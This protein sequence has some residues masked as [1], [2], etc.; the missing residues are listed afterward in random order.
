[1]SGNLRS[2]II[3]L[4]GPPGVGKTTLAFSIAK[5]MK[6]NFVKISVGGITDEAELI[7]HRRTYIGANPGRI[8]SSLKKAKSMNPV[9]LIDEI[10]KMSYS[11]KGDPASTMLE[12]LDPEQ[13]KYFSDNYIEEEFDLSK[14][15]FVATANNIEDIPEALRDRLEIVTLSGYTEYEKLDIAKK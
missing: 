9:F 4:V 8:I 7:G 15:M 1:M 3:C 2:P 13:N 10:D 11:Y 6:R 14:V 5:A 12:I